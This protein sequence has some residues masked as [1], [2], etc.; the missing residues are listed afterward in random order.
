MAR[1]CFCQMPA[2]D[3]IFYLIYAKYLV[4]GIPTTPYR[5]WHKPGRARSASFGHLHKN[6]NDS[7]GSRAFVHY[8]ELIEF[9]EL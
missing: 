4:K 3:C 5:E 9:T 8:R 2:A 1:E 6:V 7:L